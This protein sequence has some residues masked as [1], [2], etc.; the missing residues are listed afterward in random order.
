MRLLFVKSFLYCQILY[1]LVISLLFHTWWVHQ[2]LRLASNKYRYRHQADARIRFQTSST[3][4]G[5][6]TSLQNFVIQKL[7]LV[8]Q[9]SDL[10]AA[11][12]SASERIWTPLEVIACPIFPQ[13]SLH[14]VSTVGMG[15]EAGSL[16]AVDIRNCNMDFD[17]RMHFD[18]PRH[19]PHQNS[20]SRQSGT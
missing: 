7:D 4:I 5:G 2:P 12:A 18:S 15:Y 13:G 17:D 3:A 8:M 20:S 14:L 6:A 19:R 16:V 1:D 9:K 11:P 10:P